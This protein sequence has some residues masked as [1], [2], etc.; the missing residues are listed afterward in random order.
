MGLIKAGGR[1]GG[2]GEGGEPLSSQSHGTLGIG[3]QA[4][5]QKCE[6]IKDVKKIF[7]GPCCC[8]KRTCLE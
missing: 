1:E 3:H 6:K 7:K 2:P 8:H 4:R 5:L